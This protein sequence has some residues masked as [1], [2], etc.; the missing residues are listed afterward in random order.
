[1]AAAEADGETEERKADDTSKPS[2]TDSAAATP[3]PDTPVTGHLHLDRSW[4]DTLDKREHLNVVLIGHVDAG[5]STTAGN[6]LVLT[7]QVDKRT[8]DKFEREAKSLNRESWYMAFVMDTSEEERAKGKTVEVG[9][10]YF[11]TEHKRYTILDAPGHKNYVPNMISGASQADV[12]VLVISARRGE[13]EAGF[14]RSG[15]TREHALLAKTLGVTKLV[16]AVNKMDEPTVR[17]SQERFEGIVKKLRPFL[18]GCGYKVKHDVVFLPMSGLTGANIKDP[19]GA[20]APWWKGPTLFQALDETEV[21]GRSPDAPLRIPVLD[22][23]NDRGTVAM[24]KVET[25]VIY[26]GQ[27]L[28]IM[29]TRKPAEVQNVMLDDETELPGARPGENL[30]VRL[31]GVGDEDVLKG[32]VLCDAAHPCAAVHQFEA[33][34]ML[35]QLLEHRSVFTAGYRAVLHIHTLV[36][37]CTITRLLS[38]TDPAKKNPD[39]TPVVVRKPRFAK[40]NQLVNVRIRVPRS[41]CV[42]TYTSAAPLGRFTLRDEGRTIAIGKITKL[43]K[44]KAGDE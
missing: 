34:I 11:A 14:D 7:D 29:P 43:P 21:P 36:E 40:S 42:D 39:G 3:T 18:R 41:I 27:R 5:K 20:A 26:N 10:A 38:S 6:V 28:L 22:R 4:L 37:E 32:F 35:L 16:V 31:R 13:F 17:W 25:G 8:I 23:L 1:M 9:R 19:V 33:Q 2:G 24:G 15:Q 30:R 12:G 44:D